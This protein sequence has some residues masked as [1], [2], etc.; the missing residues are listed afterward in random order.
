[1]RTS[2]VLSLCSASAAAA[3]LL[4]AADGGAVV[5]TPRA[6][7][8]AVAQPDAAATTVA[9]GQAQAVLAR[10][11]PYVGLPG[12]A[13]SVGLT[14]AQVENGAARATAAAA[15]L[16]LLGTLVG[17]S[18]GDSAPALP[19]PINADSEGTQKVERDPFAAPGAPAV[20]ADPSAPSV[21]LAHE[22]AEATKDPVAARG[23]TTGP[24]LAMP[25]LLEISGGQSRSESTADK[26][27]SDVTIGSLS[28]GGGAVVLNGLHWTAAQVGKAPATAAFDLGGMVVNGQ[29][30]PLSGPAEMA[31]AVTKAN[32]A[33]APA[34]LALSVP[35]RTA[36]AS[37]GTVAPMVIQ[38]RNPE[39][40]VGPSAQAN[41]AVKPVLNELAKAII[42]ANPDAA[43]A[44]IVL[45]AATGAAGGRSGGRLELGGVSARFARVAVADQGS[46]GVLPAGPSVPSLPSLP[47]VGGMAPGSAGSAGAPGAPGQS[48]SF[49]SPSGPG[50]A[51]P[52]PGS[53][54]AGAVPVE[55]GAAVPGP[56]GVTG[57]A[58]PT[59]SDGTA[60]STSI[61]PAAAAYVANPAGSDRGSASLALGL[62]L[63]AV[64]VLAVGDRIRIRRLTR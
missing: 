53:Y 17:A 2:R 14:A 23:V 45:N 21:G 25:G 26:A 29:A 40:L 62:G 27:V 44:Q 24:A 57:E 58:A 31:D 49:G 16:G 42:A 3:V 56:P 34:G 5:E 7:A 15:D 11:V 9:A 12:V 61:D 37:G 50:A 8:P 22:L 18:A 38:V 33:L 60:T 28:L 64:L 59:G 48:A 10:L 20:P 35:G 4:A 13:A 51:L 39:T 47:A 55:A 19:S 41:E 30:M 6:A 46:A 43:A 1:M 54:E 36:D 32:E 52:G 63:F